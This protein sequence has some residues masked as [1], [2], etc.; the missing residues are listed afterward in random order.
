MWSLWFLKWFKL[1]L[2]NK[3]LINLSSSFSHKNRYLLQRG[4]HQCL[5]AVMSVRSVSLSSSPEI[6]RPPIC[7]LVSFTWK[8]SGCNFLWDKSGNSKVWPW[9]NYK[10]LWITDFLYWATRGE[11][12]WDRSKVLCYKEQHC[13]HSWNVR[14]MN[15]GKLEVVNQEMARVNTDIL[16]ISKLKWTGMGEFNWD[17]HYIYYCVQ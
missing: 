15:Q 4:P 13:I 6:L 3:D 17:D 16:R 2:K 9:L 5:Q 10:L 7:I 8:Y 12:W 14:S 1:E 11:M